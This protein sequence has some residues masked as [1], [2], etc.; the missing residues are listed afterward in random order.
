MFM[1]ESGKNDIVTWQSYLDHP[2]NWKP[3]ISN[4]QETLGLDN[5]RGIKI[6]TKI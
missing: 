3:T 2:N 4:I 5:I 6:L 1:H